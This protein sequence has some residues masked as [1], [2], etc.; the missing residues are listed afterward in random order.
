M[1]NKLFCEKVHSVCRYMRS[2]YEV[3]KETHYMSYHPDLEQE[4]YALCDK[5][6]IKPNVPLKILFGRLSGR[7]TEIRYYGR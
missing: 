2:K 3:D 1:K 7:Q 6:G 5:E 4:I